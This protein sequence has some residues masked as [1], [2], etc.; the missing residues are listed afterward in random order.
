MS[1]GTQFMRATGKHFALTLISL[2]AT[3]AVAASAQVASA[4]LQPIAGVIAEGTSVEF[5][6]DGFEG[7]EGPIALPD[8]SLIFTETRANRITQIKPDGTVQPFLQNTNGANGLAF[9]KQGELV[10]VQN[11]KPQVGVIYPADKAKNWVSEFEGK[12]FQ[13]PND[14]TI[15]KRGGVYFTDIGVVPKEPNGEPARPGVYYLTSDGA[16]KKVIG[17]VERPNGV[18]LSA[19]EKTL[20]LANTAGEYVLSYPVLGDGRL[21]PARQFAKLGGYEKN[22]QG[23]LSSGADGLAIDNRGRLYVASNLGIQIFDAKGRA[24]GVIPLAQ[25]PQ[26]LAFA[27]ADK[28]T[29]Y[30][31]GR[32]VAYKIA[33]LT[34][35]YLGRAK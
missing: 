26:N 4:P 30:V 22:E 5:I 24:L 13:R 18:L 25:K 27:G 29:L 23:V 9:N 1:M 16:I 31:V 14:I 3:Y 7:T 8:G 34:P 20:Y 33:V 17:N 11:L 28:K 35:G 12:G 10:A 19:D 32:G 6:K 2:V 21:G 15:N